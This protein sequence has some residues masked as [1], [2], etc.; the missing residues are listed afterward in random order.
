[1]APDQTVRLRRL[2]LIHAG[3]KPIMLVL[4][5]RGSYNYYLWLIVMPDTKIY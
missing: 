3:H 5:W 4:S 2:D 1:M